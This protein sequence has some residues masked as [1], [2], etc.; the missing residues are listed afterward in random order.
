MSP[1]RPGPDAIFDELYPRSADCALGQFR[2]R[3][4]AHQYRWPYRATHA[5]LGPASRVLD[6]GCGN[7][8]FTHFLLQSGHLVSAFAFGPPAPLVEHWLRRAPERLR[9]DA[10]AEAEPVRLPYADA[11]FDAVAS[12]G[13]LEHVRECGGDETAS[14]REIHR[15]LR[16]GGTFL[17]FHFPNRWSWIEALTYFAR[18]RHHH[19]FT[20]RRRDILAL[21]A[22]ANFEL[23]DLRR[24]NAVPRNSFGALP[25]ALQTSHVVSGLVNAADT[26][27]GALLRPFCQ[28]WGFVLRKL[29]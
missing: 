22:A 7:G 26:V 9:Y 12:V 8:H 15:V 25:R 4:T 19:Q 13:V 24:Y 14:L 5:H 11:S 21:V 10:G 17:C 18:S 1:P 6:W 28:N 2:S 23:L 27:L 16:P 29:A 3:P 20:Y